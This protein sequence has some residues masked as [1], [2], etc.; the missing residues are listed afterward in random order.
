MANKHSL[1]ELIKTSGAIREFKDKNVPMPL[2]NKIIEA[3]RW[4]LS[5]LG[6]QPWTLISIKNRKI[7]IMIARLLNEKSEHLENGV[8][9]V[10]RVTS[11]I[12][13]NAN[14][15]VLIYNNRKLE[16]RAEKFGSLYV[17]RAYIAELQAIGGVVQNMHLMTNNLGLGCVWLDAPTFCANEINAALNTNDELIAILAIGYPAV[18]PHRSKRQD[19]NMNR[20]FV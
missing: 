17:K 3:G 15:L 6:F 5:V 10:L 8:N 4:G 18:K 9:I 7:I 12:I 19:N 11:K 14:T 20:R 13:K 1:L 16:K 2:I